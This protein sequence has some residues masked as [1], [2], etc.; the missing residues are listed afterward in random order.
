MSLNR[1]CFFLKKTFRFFSEDSGAYGLDIGTNIVELLDD[2]LEIIPDGV[3]LK[4][5]MTNPP[6]MMNQLQYV[7]LSFNNFLEG[8]FRF[9]FCLFGFVNFDSRALLAVLIIPKC[10]VFCIVRFSPEVMRF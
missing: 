6:Y 8:F 1:S 10:I 3:M 5:G 2:I 9:D 7:S 4:M